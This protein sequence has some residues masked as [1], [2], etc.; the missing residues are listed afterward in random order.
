M[1][2]SN[3]YEN[4]KIY[5]IVDNAYAG[6]YIGSTVQ[7]L[8]NRMASHRKRYKYYK[9]GKANF[10][11]VYELFDLYGVENCKIEL[12]EK[13]P[14]EN[15]EQLSK[16]EG[17]HIKNETCIN[18]NVAGRTSNEWYADHREQVKEHV[19]QYAMA[20]KE[21][22]SANNKAYARANKEKISANKKAYYE[23]N[24]EKIK[25][26]KHKWGCEKVSCPSC[27]KE[28]TRDSLSRHNKKFHNDME[29]ETFRQ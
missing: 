19:R 3:K 10:V 23:N 11:A 28:I 13:Y 20:N 29:K 15:I 4:A 9:T 24:I 17:H 7:P 27:N 8:S 16:R 5:K 18:K 1:E 26:Y 25:L 6:C 2:T 12:I 22:I 21:K 14:C